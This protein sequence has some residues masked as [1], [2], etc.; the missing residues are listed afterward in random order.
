MLV[1]SRLFND[2]QV[3]SADAPKFMHVSNI[4]N[5]IYASTLSR[6]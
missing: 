4:L 2:S 6:E 3:A 5:G 1:D